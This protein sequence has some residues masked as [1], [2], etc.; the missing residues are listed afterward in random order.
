MITAERLRELFSY[1]PTTG[2]FTRRIS[3][4]NCIKRGAIAGCPD[5]RGYLR[6]Q[7]NGRKYSVHRLVWFY[8]TASWP[9]D[10]D[11]INGIKSDN[12]FSNLREAT[13]SEN[14]RNTGKRANNKSGFKGVSWKS[15]NNCWV[16]QIMVH[17]KKKHLGY[18]YTPEEAHA[19]YCDAAEEL[20]GEFAHA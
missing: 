3:T 18:F 20:H 16:A 10:I 5:R 12:R 9:A 2:S 1:D 4:S 7:I 15:N 19:V 8:V 13:R 14:I 17:R 6:I 11:H